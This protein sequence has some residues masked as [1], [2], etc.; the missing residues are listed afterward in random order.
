[1]FGVRT[2]GFVS[3]VTRTGKKVL[4]TAPAKS[5]FSRE[6][7][8]ELVKSFVVFVASWGVLYLETP[9]AAYWLGQYG[10]M[11]PLLYLVFTFIKKYFSELKE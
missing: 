1:M 7:L 4:L 6:F 9:E 8:N 10:W 5:L 3:G 2:K 11:V